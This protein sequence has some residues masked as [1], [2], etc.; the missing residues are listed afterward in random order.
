MHIN[1]HK[2]LST[3]HGGGGPGAGPIAVSAALAPYL[4][5][6]HVAASDGDDGAYRFATP[7]RSDRPAGAFHGNFGV[8]LRAYAYMRTLGARRG[9][10]R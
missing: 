5:S 3:P 10:A 9:C 7:A 6:P 4:P 8:L 1:V 2:T